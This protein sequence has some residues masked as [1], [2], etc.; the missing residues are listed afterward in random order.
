MS[1]KEPAPDLC[2]RPDDEQT[3]WLIKKIQ[4]YL[5]SQTQSV[6]GMSQCVSHKDKKGETNQS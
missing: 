6:D 3:D 1:N 4:V 5:Y 2:S